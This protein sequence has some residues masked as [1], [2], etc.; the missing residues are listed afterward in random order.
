MDENDHFRRNLLAAM[1]DQGL[2]EAELSVRAGL[3]RRA[4]TDIRE[5]RTRSP[6][7]STVFAL[8]KALGLDPGEMMGLGPRHK[9]QADLAEFLAQ[10]GEDEQARLLD[11]IRAFPAA[12]TSK[13]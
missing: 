13:Q 4:V 8:A 12:P 7:L 6:K 3:N 10:Y 5:E 2:S 11:A 9:V 1:K